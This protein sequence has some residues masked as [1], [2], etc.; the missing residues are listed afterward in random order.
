MG[1]IIGP[2]LSLAPTTTG[3]RGVADSSAVELTSNGERITGSMHDNR[4]PSC[5]RDRRGAAG[6]G[7]ARGAGWAPPRQW[8]RHQEH[9]W[10]LLLRTGGGG[11]TLRGRARLRGRDAAPISV[12]AAIELPF[13]FDR[14]PPIARRCCWR[15][16]S[17]NNRTAR[18]GPRSRRA[19]SSRRFPV[20]S[21]ARGSS[22]SARRPASRAHRRT[23]CR[24]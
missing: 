15:S 10:H 16:S 3:Y 17:A 5:R 7:H 22:T 12:P 21:S 20:T 2:T 23:R 9:P 8:R 6:A 11:A 14:L 4:R 1:E 19:A 24:G 18:A 13:G